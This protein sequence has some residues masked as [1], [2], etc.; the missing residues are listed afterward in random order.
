MLV[1]QLLQQVSILFVA[2]QQ[3]KEM[4]INLK[5]FSVR[6]TLLTIGNTMQEGSYISFI[7]I[8]TRYIWWTLF[9]PQK[10]VCYN[11]FLVRSKQ[12]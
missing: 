11:F 6:R 9:G 7:F 1:M 3:L 10:K 4:L 2:E 12:F 5:D 8:Y